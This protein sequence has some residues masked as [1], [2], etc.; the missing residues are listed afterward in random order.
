MDLISK[1]STFQEQSLPQTPQTELTMINETM[2]VMVFTSTSETSCCS[3][4]RRSSH[5]STAQ[6]LTSPLCCFFPSSNRDSV[7]DSNLANR[8]HIVPLIKFNDSAATSGIWADLERR[9]RK[10]K[11]QRRT[12]ERVIFFFFFKVAQKVREEGRGEKEPANPP[13]SS[14][15]K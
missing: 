15:F 13:P 1:P 6:S 9:E 5:S 2:V 8:S 3:A 10:N 7:Y 11:R 4:W 14:S 12:E